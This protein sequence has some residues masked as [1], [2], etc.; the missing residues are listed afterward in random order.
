MGASVVHLFSVAF[1]VFEGYVQ[2]SYGEPF[3]ENRDWP[4]AGSWDSEAGKKGE[5][6]YALC[7]GWVSVGG[8]VAAR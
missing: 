7:S 4:V 2:V 3:L 5:G 6:V 8:D 1:E